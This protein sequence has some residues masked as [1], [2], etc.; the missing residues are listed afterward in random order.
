M[1]R[2][3]SMRND[4]YYWILYIVH[5]VFSEVHTDIMLTSLLHNLCL[6]EWF[7]CALF[8]HDWLTCYAWLLVFMIVFFFHR[9]L[10]SLYLSQFSLSIF[11]LVM[12]AY[13]FIDNFVN[14]MS[15]DCE[16]YN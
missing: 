16:S 3:D 12:L 15:C 7:K 11:F 13:A 4:S 6:D 2:I 9:A 8:R 5:N 1:Q 14:G 10:T